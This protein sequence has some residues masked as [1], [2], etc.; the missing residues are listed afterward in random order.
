MKEHDL[1]WHIAYWVPPNHATE[2]ELDRFLEDG[3]GIPDSIPKLYTMREFIEAFNNQEISDTG[4][5]YYNS[6]HNDGK[7]NNDN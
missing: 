3:T 4:W 7:E 1:V 5:L 6:R 2:D